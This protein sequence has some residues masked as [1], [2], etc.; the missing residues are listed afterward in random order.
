MGCASM[1][2]LTSFRCAAV[3]RRA[4]AAWT[5]CRARSRSGE[6]TVLESSSSRSMRRM[7]R[8]AASRMSSS[9]TVD[10]GSLFRTPKSSVERRIRAGSST[11]RG[12]RFSTS[13]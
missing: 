13:D 11:W 1:C 12:L 5:R 7:H 4:A 9:V 3:R 6:A 2:C 10:R 8:V